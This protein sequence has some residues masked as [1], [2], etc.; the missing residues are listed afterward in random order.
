MNAICLQ[1]IGI[2]KCWYCFLWLYT[3]LHLIF[4]AWDMQIN[5]RK[6]RSHSNGRRIAVYYPKIWIKWIFALRLLE[7]LLPDE[8]TRISLKEIFFAWRLL[9]SC[10][11]KRQIAMLVCCGSENLSFQCFCRNSVGTD[12]GFGDWGRA[13]LAGGCF[14]QASISSIRSALLPWAWLAWACR[15]LSKHEC[16]HGR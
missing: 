6:C 16:W 3:P 1:K 2:V 13:V 7:D 11:K 12:C 9:F 14:Q 8:K 10:V 5:P 15:F 4:R